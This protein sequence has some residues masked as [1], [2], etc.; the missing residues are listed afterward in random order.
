MHDP[1]LPPSGAE[2]YAL[3]LEAINEAVYD[4]DATNGTIYYAPQLGAMLG[5]ENER[6]RTVEDWTSRIDPDDLPSYRQ[7]WRALFR[8]EQA[9]LDCQ[10]RYRAGDGRWRWAHQHGIALRDGAGR[11]RRVVGAV[12]DI[13]ELRD[14]QELQ[15]ATAEVLRAISRADFDLETVLQ[16]LVGTVAQLTR[17]EAAILWRYRDGAYHYAAGYLMNPEFES[18]ERA[19]PIRPGEET[20]VGRAAL[21]QS[22][23]QIVDAWTDPDY[24]P[25]HEARL[26]GVRSMLAVPLVREGAPI[27]MFS[28]GRH[29]VDPFT[30][31]QISLIDSFADQ[32]V[33]AIENTRLIAELH[34]RTAELEEALEYQGATSEIL[35]VINSSPSD[36]APVFDAVLEKA[37]RLCDADAGLLWLYD[38]E[39]FRAAALRDLPPAYAEFVTRGPVRPGAETTLA[40]VIKDPRV[41]S[42][43]DI[44]VAPP[45]I[46][47]RAAYRRAR[48]AGRLPQHDRDP[49]RQGRRGARR[50]VA[51]S[52]GSQAVFREAP[53]TDGGVRDAGGHRTRKCPPVRGKPAA[54]RRA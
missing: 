1:A 37:T 53:R 19:T 54:R 24:G 42:R 8:G 33:I 41:R 3:A 38:G 7:A 52:A 39:V 9:R 46:G 40:Q 22:T 49:A 25:K 13:T 26:G 32:A 21:R 5:L 17:A 11:V 15:A 31:Q 34:Q 47:A 12:G 16:T 36:P 29:A 51:V 10:Y 6:L 43:D 14:A 35:R 27:G 18:I 44:R 48:G 20:V 50:D 23:V 28:V 30:P 45:Y 2:R 4:Y